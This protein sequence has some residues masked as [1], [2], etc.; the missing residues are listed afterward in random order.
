M[1]FPAHAVFF[2]VFILCVRRRACVPSQGSLHPSSLHLGLLHGN[3][4]CLSEALGARM[5]PASSMSLESPG[6]KG[7]TEFM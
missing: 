7:L 4:Q 3:L 5:T 2:D 1:I 6:D